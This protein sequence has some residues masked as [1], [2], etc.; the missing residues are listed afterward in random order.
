LGFR[1]ESSSS[2]RHPGIYVIAPLRGPSE[3]PVAHQP[4]ERAR[5]RL[6]S[7]AAHA[8]SRHRMTAPVLASGTKI[9]I[10]ST[11]FD[12]LST[13]PLVGC[14]VTLADWSDIHDHEASRLGKSR[15]QPLADFGKPSPMHSIVRAS[16]LTRLVSGPRP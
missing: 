4:V 12:I 11:R 16:W 10:L 9:I 7:V 6:V 2:S 15:A 5:P 1:L 3:P 14:D 8:G 13:M